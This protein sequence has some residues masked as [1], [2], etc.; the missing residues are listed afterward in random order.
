MN[1]ELIDY[2]KFS[3]KVRE[4]LNGFLAIE[5]NITNEEKEQFLNNKQLH[6]LLDIHLSWA[7]K[8]I[9]YKIYGINQ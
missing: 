9:D 3:A 8:M 4:L 1:K 2:L 5:P 7:R 6:K